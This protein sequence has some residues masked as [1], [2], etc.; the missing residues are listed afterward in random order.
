MN[1]K[2]EKHFSKRMNIQVCGLLQLLTGTDIIKVLWKVSVLSL[3]HMK[4]TVS[5]RQLLAESS[6]IVIFYMIFFYVLC[7]NYYFVNFFF[8]IKRKQGISNCFKPL[9]SSV[10]T[11]VASRLKSEQKEKGKQILKLNTT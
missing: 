3:I 6:V 5:V 8:S 11:T 9:I 4:I 1:S 2:N 7:S 10:F